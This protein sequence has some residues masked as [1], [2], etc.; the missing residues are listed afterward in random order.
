MIGPC[1]PLVVACG[2]RILRE[3][4]RT[5]LGG[6]LRGQLRTTLD[7]AKTYGDRPLGHAVPVDFLYGRFASE[8]YNAGL[9]PSETRN[10]I[11]ALS[12]GDANDK[13]KSRIL[14]L[15]YMLGRIAAEADHHGVLAKPETIADLLIVDLAGD[16]QLRKEVP[17]LLAALQNDGAVIEVGGEWRLQ[18]KESAEWEAAYR[19]EERSCLADPSV[20][21]RF[22]RDLLGQAIEAGLS[23]AASVPHGQSKQQRRIH[24]LQ[25]TDKTP[26]DGI[27]LRL[28]SGWDEELAAAEREITAAS[29][30][31]PTV[32]LLIP[33][34]RND[35]LSRVLTT[36]RAAEQVLQLRGVP[37]TDAGREAQAAMQ[38]RANKALSA[39]NE[40]VR[41]AVAQAKVMQAGGKIVQGSPAD[42]VKAAASNALA[43][44][45]PQF[46]DGDHPGWEKVREKA[47]RKDPDALK[48]VD[49]AGAP[50]AHPVCK[51]LLSDLGS[52]RK[53]SD[54]RNKLTSS[55]LWLVPGCGRWCVDGSGQCWLGTRHRR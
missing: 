17:L 25:P 15:V 20:L 42:A 34:H 31:D 21:P 38:S 12:G 16:D 18:T 51:S 22:R 24:R 26:G 13:L 35:D 6:T 8:A 28:H 40:I 54:L 3:L 50:E 52:G 10:R 41:E 46:S 32:H 23:G 14:M 1:F 47:A 29:T 9:L 30:N 5:G 55:A 39:A 36:R 11:E 33:R 45:Y 53:G 2:R 19:T 44:L 7:A 27:A 49:H 4:D 37:Q 43:R 48:A